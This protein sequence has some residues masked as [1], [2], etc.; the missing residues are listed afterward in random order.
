MMEVRSG[1]SEKPSFRS[2][3]HPRMIGYGSAAYLS[4]FVTVCSCRVNP[5][6]SIP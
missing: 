5:I 1:Q 6:I 2:T 4:G 3:I